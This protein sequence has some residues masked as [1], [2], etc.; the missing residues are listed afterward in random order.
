[1]RSNL[2]KCVNSLGDMMIESDRK[3][4][5]KEVYEEVFMLRGS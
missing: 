4:R 2:E 1:M 5:V 3:A